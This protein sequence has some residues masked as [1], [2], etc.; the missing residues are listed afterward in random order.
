MQ[1]CPIRVYW[2]NINIVYLVTASCVVGSSRVLSSCISLVGHKDLKDVT[3]DP[4]RFFLLSDGA[5]PC[6]LF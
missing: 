3:L 4:V 2:H 6:E 1:T 5:N